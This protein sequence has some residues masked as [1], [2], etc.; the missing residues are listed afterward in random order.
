MEVLIPTSSQCSSLLLL[1]LHLTAVTATIFGAPV[2]AN[3]S[4][5]RS[6]RVV[7][8]EKFLREG[9][10]LSNIRPDSL[11][12]AEPGDLPD[13]PGG[14]LHHPREM[15]EEGEHH[16]QTEGL[17][18]DGRPG[19]VRLLHLCS[20]QT[21]HWLH[22]TEPGHNNNNNNLIT[23]TIFLSTDVCRLQVFSARRPSLLAI[24][25]RF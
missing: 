1:L 18:G 25:R 5:L 13:R 22:G 16:L 3:L 8:T 21:Q 7:V 20:V 11:C 17:A 23:I 2:W 14:V 12:W 15:R 9:Q 4:E 6:Y 19:P 24:L 10:R